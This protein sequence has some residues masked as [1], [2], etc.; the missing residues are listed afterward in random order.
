M[1]SIVGLLWHRYFRP[2][3]WTVLHRPASAP[4]AKKGI[5]QRIAKA[6]AQQDQVRAALDHVAE[7]TGESAADLAA[8][9]REAFREAPQAFAEAATKTLPAGP[10]CGGP[11]VLRADGTI[12][13]KRSDR[14]FGRS[15]A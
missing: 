11:M 9:C 10:S 1:D 8:A 12:A 14:P 6:Q 4:L 7:Q 13:Q 5:G 15:L 3:P 2:V